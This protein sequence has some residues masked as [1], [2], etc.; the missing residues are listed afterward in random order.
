MSA[1]RLPPYD[2][3]A[4][5]AVN[6]SLLIDGSAIHETIVFLKPKDFYSEPNR[7]I[8][9]ACLTLY[10]RDEAINQITVAQELEREGRL[11][12]SGGAAYLSRLVSI[13]PTSLDIEH[14]GRIVY[15]LSIMRQLIIAADSIS[16]IGYDAGPDVNVSLNKAEDLLFQLR[17]EHM[18]DFVHI[19]NILDGYFEPPPAPSEGVAIPQIFTGLHGLDDL[20]GGFKRSEM[21]ILAAR[22]SVGKT[23]LA[24]N[25]ARNAA[26]DQG[27]CVAIFSLEM[28]K[29]ALAQRLLSGE[30]GINANRLKLTL[31]TE[32]EERKV[33]EAIGVLSEASIFI[34]D[35]PQV[36]VT[37]MRSKASRLN[38]ERKIDLIV[39]DYLQLLQGDTHNNNRVQEISL[40][41]RSLKALARELDVPVLAVSQLSRAIEKRDKHEPMLSDL[42]DS[43]SIEQDADVVIFVSREEMIFRNEED[44]RAAHPDEEYPRG[45]ADI[46]VAKNRNGPTGNTKVRF[47][48]RL[49]KFDNLT[50]AGVD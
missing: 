29:D 14:Y 11:E 17:Q 3:D 10:R 21:I 5:E 32:E 20:L 7:W 35:S 42:R 38:F 1:E 28:S 18:L 44:W 30:T 34:D 6:G 46:I 2:I 36:Q 40:I 37:E 39:V 45:I 13:V 50:T 47:I 22:P 16:K 26:V 8:Y 33:M 15:R 19:K 9:Q 12:K 25:I 24:L 27:A 31:N 23:S 48:N 49:T 43:G 4:E 41:S